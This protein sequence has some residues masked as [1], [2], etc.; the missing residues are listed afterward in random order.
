MAT[1]S[2]STSLTSSLQMWAGRVLSAVA[3]LF[4]AMDAAMKILRTPPAVDFTVGKL[5]YPQSA[6]AAIGITLLLFTILYVIPRTSV[7]G[8]VLLTAYLGGA[9]ASNVRIGAPPFNVAFPIVFAVLVWAGLALRDRRLKEL[10]LR[11]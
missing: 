10:L 8:V 9:V 7:L 2:V 4:F 6:V 3:V 11:F 5:G 1:A